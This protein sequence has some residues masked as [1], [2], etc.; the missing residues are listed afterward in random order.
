MHSKNHGHCDQNLRSGNCCWR[1]LSLN[2]H[3]FPLE[4]I[5]NSESY[6]RSML[7]KVTSSRCGCTRCHSHLAVISCTTGSLWLN[8]ISKFRQPFLTRLA[9]VF[10]FF[11]WMHAQPIFWSG[12]HKCWAGLTLFPRSFFLLCTA[13]LHHVLGRNFSVKQVRPL[14]RYFKAWAFCSNSVDYSQKVL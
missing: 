7:Y 5:V 1:L 12:T 13:E 4:N 14:P 9:L 3:I 6:R 8:L 2:L 11:K 10:F